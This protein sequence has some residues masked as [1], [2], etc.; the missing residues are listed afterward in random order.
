MRNPYIR[1]ICLL[2][3]IITAA[4]TQA[5][6]PQAIS[7]Q[8]VIRSPSGEIMKNRS[9]ATRISILKDQPTGVVIFSETHKS[10]TNE[11]GMLGIEIGRGVNVTGK[12]ADIQWGNGKYYIQSETDINGGTQYGL[13]VTT[14]ILSVPYA[15]H[16][17]TASRLVNPPAETDP[18]FGKSVAYGILQADTANW[19]HK[20]NA[21]ITSGGL[22]LKGDTLSLK[23]AEKDPVFSAS[24]AAGIT[25]KDTTKWN[26]KQEK[27]KLGRGL[28]W[29][30][31][32]LSES[33]PFFQQSLAAGITS[34]D[35]AKWNAKQQALKA[36]SGISISGNTISATSG[37]GGFTHYI[38][39]YYDGGLIFYLW[40]DSLGKEHGLIMDIKDL[41]ISQA[42]SNVATT[43]I[44]S[45]AQHLGDGLKNSNA[46]VAQSGHISSAALLCLNS[47]NGG[48]SDWYLPSI[49]ELSLIWHSRFILNKRLETLSGANVFPLDVY[50]C[51]STEYSQNYVMY[52]EFFAGKLT[53]YYKSYLGRVRAV[54]NF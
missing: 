3:F 7:Y 45:T 1:Y 50:Y 41:S 5:Q 27:L 26:Q 15:L 43:L 31:D 24:V 38:G 52:C 42:Y 33:D 51:S 19:N 36:G 48:K 46:I 11:N 29:Q 17:E 6:S 44:G 40:K 22:T 25:L 18:V 10:Q 37:G 30:N 2:I 34:K 23:I 9:I 53:N 28:L 4:V 54:R 32:S 20:Q 14:Q 12:L 39:E 21:I 35:T 49:D 16:S 47:T 8:A 13:S